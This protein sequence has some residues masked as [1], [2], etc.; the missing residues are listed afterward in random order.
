[1]S[2][3]SEPGAERHNA[4]FKEQVQIGIDQVARGEFIE[5]EGMNLRIKRM[6]E[7]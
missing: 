3:P 4:W 1:M 7:P 5:E 2:W 6:L